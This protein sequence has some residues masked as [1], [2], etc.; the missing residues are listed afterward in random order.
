MNGIT[1]TV[2]N[3]IVLL[4]TAEHSLTSKIDENEVETWVTDFRQNLNGHVD[5]ILSVK[6][7]ESNFGKFNKDLVIAKINGSDVFSSVYQSVSL[8]YTDLER[9]LT[10][11]KSS[12]EGSVSPT[13][14]PPGPNSPGTGPPPLISPR[15]GPPLAPPGAGG[16]P[17]VGLT[18]C[19]AD[20]SVKKYNWRFRDLVCEKECYENVDETLRCIASSGVADT[21]KVKSSVICQ[22]FVYIMK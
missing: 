1:F 13:S 4:Y 22:Y 5:R 18:G 8:R 14:G 21:F 2:C 19:C 3:I 15:G 17:P 9:A 6:A 12:I 20:C 7:I 16:V 11:L 10:D